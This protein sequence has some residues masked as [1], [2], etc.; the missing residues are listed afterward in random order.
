VIVASDAYGRAER[1]Y[2]TMTIAI[3]VGGP[4]DDR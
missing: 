2:P 3:D 4:H 1:H